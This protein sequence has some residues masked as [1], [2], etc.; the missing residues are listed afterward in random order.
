VKKQI[1]VATSNQHKLKE[2]RELFKA[3]DLEIVG[4]ADIPACEEPEETGKTFEANAAIKALDYARQARCLTLAEDSGLSCDALDG[5]PGIF[6]ARFSG[7]EQNDDANNAK[8]LKLL[9]TL[10]DNC[11]SAHYT[12]AISLASP[13]EVIQTFFGEVHGS[14]ARELRGKNG[15]GYDPLFYYLPFKMTFGEASPEMKQSVSHRAAA[16]A[17]LRDYLTENWESLA[18]KSHCK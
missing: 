7:E 1:L 10:P 18:A 5:A 8:L 11:R 14:I 15:F 9:A 12:S 3:L 16:F 4:L 13:E 2:F 6:S 17:K